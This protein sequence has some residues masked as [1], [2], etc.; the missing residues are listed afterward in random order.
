MINLKENQ[1]N[2]D[3]NFMKS[4][5]F[6][7]SLLLSINSFS[8]KKYLEKI[9]KTSIHKFTYQ[10]IK[11]EKNLKL[12][13][14]KPRKVKGLKPLIIYVH[15]GGFSGGQ[16]NDKY[17][18]DFSKEMASYGYAVA[19]I[20][21]RL[22]MKGIGFGCNTKS[23]LKI[24][25]FNEVSKD[26]SYAIKY[27]IKR[28][29]KFKIDTTKVIL[30]GSSAGAE[31]V[32][33][34]AYVYENEILDSS[35]KFAG[36]IGMAGAITTIDKITND[37]AIPTQLFHG[38]KDDL[39]PY[40]IAP[41]HYCKKENIGYLRLYGSRAIADQLKSI[42]KSYYLYSVKNGDHSWNSRP[43]YQCKNEILDFLYFD[44]LQKNERQTEVKI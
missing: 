39:V 22:T 11:K 26:I 1:N 4:T 10:R 9:A 18:V 16:R 36:I 34:L 33:N 32:L 42:G 13:F 21:Y 25:A 40:N 29:R 8:Q 23:D 6:I 30:V 14:Y 5:I 3:Y 19:S 17:A 35:F 41:H 28:N 27:I 31:A 37:K 20:S 44:V 15:G 43:I 38:E 2:Y 7:F 24:K 12:D